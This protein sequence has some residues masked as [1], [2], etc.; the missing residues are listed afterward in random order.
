M[1]N[2][3]KTL[4]FWLYLLPFILMIV[5]VAVIYTLTVNADGS[6]LYLKQLAA[7]VVGVGAMLVATFYDYRGLKAWAVWTY[8]FGVLGLIVV[9]LVGASAYGSQRWIN[10]GPIQYQPGELEKLIVIITLATVLGR[11]AGV[12]SNRRFLGSIALLAVPV[13]AV[14]VQPDLGTALVCTAAGLGVLFHARLR[15]W[16]RWFLVGGLIALVAIFA[17]SFHGTKPFDN[18]LKSYQK[19]RLA[20]F[21]DPSRDSSGSGY[22]VIQSVIAVGSGGLTGKGLGYGSQS[23]LN[24]LPVAYADFIF[25]A[26]AESWGLLGS[27]AILVIY[28]MLLMRILQAARLA[29]DEFGMLLCIGIAVKIAVEV[30]VNVGMNVRLMP[31]TGIPL[32]FLSYGGTTLV[33]NAL[34]I[35]LAQSVVIRYKRLTF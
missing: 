3:F 2:R 12:I 14:L 27:V 32:P 11:G 5:S 23:Q 35:G 18:L 33:T 21:V 26:T 28:G 16:H 29:K 9:R 31:V 15:R 13:L 34:C 8:L 4:D 19:D 7:G 20:S 6:G 24:F 25:A 10:I 17:L 30:L 1:W 22:N